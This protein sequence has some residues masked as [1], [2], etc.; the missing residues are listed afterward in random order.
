MLP[1]LFEFERHRREGRHPYIFNISG[2]IYFIIKVLVA[3]G[4]VI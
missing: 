2:L 1:C 3:K 4:C